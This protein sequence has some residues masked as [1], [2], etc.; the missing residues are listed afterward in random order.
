[1]HIRRG[2]PAWSWDPS[3]GSQLQGFSGAYTWSARTFY[4]KEACA[5]SYSVPPL[6]DAQ[7]SESRQERSWQAF[8]DVLEGP[9]SKGG[10]CVVSEALQ[11][12]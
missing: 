8:S 4:E 5:R 9:S 6:L 10:G 11:M 12:W 3:L 7:Q 2:D 1:M